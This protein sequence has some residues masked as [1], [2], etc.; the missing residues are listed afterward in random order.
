MSLKNHLYISF[1]SSVFLFI[2][3]SS[4]AST[5]FFCSA[6]FLAFFFSSSIWSTQRAVAQNQQRFW[7]LLMNPLNYFYWHNDH[8]HTALLH[9]M[10]FPLERISSY[11]WH[12]TIE[13][14]WGWLLQWPGCWALL[15]L[16]PVQPVGDWTVTDSSAPLPTEPE[17]HG[18]C[19]KAYSASV[20]ER[21]TISV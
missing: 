4:R 7:K 3:W 17:S 13:Q 12:K 9:C 19:G 21:K 18:H 8:V 14:K 10:V 20:P 2:S 11:E 1:W 15:S 6:I 16:S 5:A